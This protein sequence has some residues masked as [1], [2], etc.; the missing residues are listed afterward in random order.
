M[1]L[2]G[3]CMGEM[4]LQTSLK[5]MLTL[6][7][8]LIQSVLH[9]SVTLS[10]LSSLHLSITSSLLH[11]FT[12]TLSLPSLLHS[13]IASLSHFVT[14][15]VSLALMSLDH[16]LLPRHWCK[17]DLDLFYPVNKRISSMWTLRPAFR[18]EV[19]FLW[20]R[21][22]PLHSPG[23]LTVPGHQRTPR[24]LHKDHRW[25]FINQKSIN[26]SFFF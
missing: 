10:Y 18:F 7:E 2:V 19:F 1:K 13:F 25:L 12:V 16:C 20:L 11:L 8:V 17:Q 26:C 14:R 24:C 22:S 5:N 9:L 23:F 3:L 6:S 21:F 15:S 4:F